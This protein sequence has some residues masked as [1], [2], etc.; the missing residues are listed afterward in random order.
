[1]FAEHFFL[2]VIYV[3][4]S[5]LFWMLLVSYTRTVKDPNFWKLLDPM[6]DCGTHITQSTT[7]SINDLDLNVMRLAQ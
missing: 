6:V 5:G 2:V 7:V 1:M 4:C 3:L